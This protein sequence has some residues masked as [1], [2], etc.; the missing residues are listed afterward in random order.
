MEF[1]GVKMTR[2]KADFLLLL[3]A[4]I[5][6]FAF[7]AQKSAM[8]SVGPFTFVSAR[9]FL[10]ALVVAPFLWVEHRN[11]EPAARLKPFDWCLIFLLCLLFFA[12]VT[13]QQAGMIKTTVTNASFLTGLY[14][15]MTPAAS[16]VIFR[17]RP[18]AIIWIAGL[19]CVLGIWLLGGGVLSAL[20]SGDVLVIL[21]ALFFSIYTALVGFVVLRVRRPI[22][23]AVAQYAVC[24]VFAGVVAIL[25]EDVA[26]SALKDVWAEVLY[27]GILSGGIAY[28]LQIIGQQHTPSGDAA[29]ILS[30]E[31]LFGALGGFLFMGDRLSF[32]AWTG[33]SLILFAILLVEVFPLLR[34]LRHG[35]L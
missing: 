23:I 18:P 2:L 3:A 6:G 30:S 35:S 4:V 26:L 21:C 24:A 28:T 25:S 9:F 17:T 15:V 1:F 12:G 20:G 11:G 33:C 16:W 7:V 22:F 32:L 5:W 31:A 14:A 8:E 27:A 10:S 34:R 13:L 19:I 29:I